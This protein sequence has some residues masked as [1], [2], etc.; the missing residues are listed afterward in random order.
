MLAHSGEAVVVADRYGRVRWASPQAARLVEGRLIYA[1]NPDDRRE[2]AAA[3]RWLA[4]EPGGHRNLS[5]RVTDGVGG[6]RPAEVDIAN[7]LDDPQIAGWFMVV[8]E[9]TGDVASTARLLH[10]ATHDSLT[11]LPNRAALL[12][13]LEAQ[14]DDPVVVLFVDLDG[15]KGVNDSLG[16]AAGDKLLVATADRLRRAVRPG[17]TVARLGGDE[18]V[19]VA[20]GVDRPSDATEIATRIRAAI[21]RP[22]PLAGRIVRLTASIGIA[23][24][25]ERRASALLADADA[26]MYRAKQAGRDRY[27]L[28]STGMADAA[29]VASE[30]VLRAAL[31]NDGLAVVF[32]PL[33]DL[34]TGALVAAEAR[35]RLRGKEGDLLG[36]APFV[37]LAERSG[38]IVSVGAGLLDQACADASGWA[39]RVG[40]V[41]VGLSAR[42]LAERRLV[43]LVESSLVCHALDPARL[44]LEVEERVLAAAGVEAWH[45]LADLKALGVGLC[46]DDFGNGGASLGYLRRARIDAIKL[47]RTFVAGLGHDSGDTEVVRAFIGLGEALGLVTAANG[48]E[49]AEQAALLADLGCQLGQGFHLGRPV[50]AGELLAA[51]A[52]ER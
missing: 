47:D 13:H 35:L 42:Q 19:V 10:R 34:H 29:R 50:L 51:R 9:T 45:N 14:G 5:C 3:F 22:V 52:A 39:G 21:C 18:F 20:S 4:V 17:D 24:G 28:F 46:V 49:T 37:D 48:I 40:Q 32:Q 27:E 12:R 43:G 16:H 33:T 1:V 41:W 31:D 25:S 11:E 23:M 2:V 44:V 26:A 8:R 6:W 36:P 7:R 30:K 38:L 15:F